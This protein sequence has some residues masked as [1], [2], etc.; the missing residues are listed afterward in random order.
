[1]DGFHFLFQPFSG[2]GQIVALVSTMSAKSA[3]AKSGLMFRESLD[4]GSRHALVCLTIGNGAA[5]QRRPN[6]AGESVHTQGPNVK[7]PYWLKLVRSG[8]T[9][10]GFVSPD[11]INWGTAVGTDTVAIPANLFVGLAVSSHNIDQFTLVEFL[12]TIDACQ[13]NATVF[14]N[15]TL[16]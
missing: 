14:M 4:P 5:F 15:V 1:M 12:P 11:G 9:L 8:D 16:S 3:W 10:T 13:Q 6:T 7:P 2:N